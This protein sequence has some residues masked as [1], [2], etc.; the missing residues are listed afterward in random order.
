MIFEIW[1]SFAVATIFLVTMSA[2][3]VLL[4]VSSAFKIQEKTRT[5][6]SK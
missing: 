3:T 5:K 4:T 2:P 6:Y 1:L